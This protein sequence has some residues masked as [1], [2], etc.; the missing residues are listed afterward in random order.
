MQ[1]YV[2]IWIS[3]LV[4]I[5][6]VIPYLI[7]ENSVIARDDRMKTVLINFILKIVN[8]YVTLVFRDRYVKYLFNSDWV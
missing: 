8:E 2:F 4:L 6:K 7:A 3:Q 1:V 5:T